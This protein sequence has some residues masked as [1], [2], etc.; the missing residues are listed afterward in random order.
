M[1]RQILILLV[2]LTGILLVS[3]NKDNDFTPVP[4]D[5]GIL[6]GDAVVFGGYLV[7]FSDTKA[8]S[9]DNELISKYSPSSVSREFTVEMYG[10]S[11]TFADSLI[12]KA[13][14]YTTDG[15]S[16]DG[17]LTAKDTSLYWPSSTTAYAFKAVA[18]NE[19]LDSDQTTADKFNYQDRLIGYGYEALKTDASDPLDNIDGLNYHTSKKWYELNKISYGTGGT[20]S[21]W[22][23]IPLFM[24]RQRSRITIILK[25]GKGVKREALAFVHAGIS[26]KD[27]IFSYSSP[28]NPTAIFPLASEE[29]IHYDADE[30]GPAQDSVSTT[31]YD[32]IVEPFN[33]LA[34]TESAITRINLSDQR[35]SYYSRND[36]RFTDPSKASEMECYNVKAGE[37]LVLVV[38]LESG[39]HIMVLSAKV[40]NWTEEESS[41]VVNDFGS[42]GDPFII[43]NRTR[44]IEFLN[45]PDQN[46]AGNVA[47]VAA[48]EIDLLDDWDPSAYTLKATLNL[49]G[50]KFLTSKQFISEVEY[51]ATLQNGT[52]VVKDNTSLTSAVCALNSG[53]INGITVT[54]GAGSYATV[55]GI[56]EKNADKIYNSTSSIPVV[57]TTGYVG[58]IAGESVSI[59]SSAPVIDG[60]TANCKVKG[61]SGVIG[62]G[63][64]GKAS[65]VVANNVFNYGITLSQ[66]SE[67]KNIVSEKEGILL[68]EQNSWPTTDLN[69]DAG[70]NARGASY[71]YNGIIDCQEDLVVSLDETTVNK[72][73]KKLAIMDNFIVNDTWAGSDRNVYYALEGNGK[74]IALTGSAN[75]KRL[76][77]EVRANMKDIVVDV[78]KTIAATEISNNSATAALAYAVNGNVEM[79]NIKVKT[80]TDAYIEA[81]NPSGIFVW[82]Y[83]G[84]RITSCQ[85]KGNVRVRLAIDLVDGQCY[86]GTI[87]SMAA[88]ATLTSCVC[89][90]ASPFSRAAD[91]H[92]DVD[93]KIFYGGIVGGTYY[94]KVSETEIY[95]PNLL[96]SDCTSNFDY[97]DTVES[98]KTHLGSIIGFAKYDDGD[99]FYHG[100]ASDCQ[101]N[102]WI[103]G[104]V[105]ISTKGLMEGKTEKDAIGKCNAIKPALDSEW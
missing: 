42:N 84:A 29:F 24:Q 71:L 59:D 95:V 78:R 55:A 26:L 76:F 73:G 89:H 31:R 70:T 35:Y 80:A 74:T 11:S 19:S 39:N 37:Q 60:C 5:D 88:D 21:K 75:A 72:P 27:T 85:F 67:F 52:I 47:I 10:K 50:A 1:I 23:T 93:N 83:N 61:S 56:A 68:A 13:R 6:A 41:T 104:Q 91:G 63:I 45:N 90:T 25:A 103:N 43:T 65:G 79:L 20:A 81:A 102:W 92:S 30:N 3:C 32:A 18:G 4:E 98:N 40:Q 36:T 34:N 99:N 97:D 7:R 49:A 44:L 15:T 38:K 22:K 82:A 77:Y 62:G 53:V 100:L 51:N 94:K 14:I 46:K 101:G 48:P 86:A 2:S 33:Y 8:Y 12:G 96:I 28:G 17:S 87:V 69:D 64:A 58:G 66:P 57:G 54:G 105:A 16:A 9:R